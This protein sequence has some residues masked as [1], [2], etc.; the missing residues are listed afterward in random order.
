[1][2]PAERA[3]P[4]SPLN[5]PDHVD[6]APATVHHELL[7][8]GAYVASVSTVYR[9]LREHGEARERR[10]QAIRPEPVA[11]SAN[12]VRPW[13]ITRL[14]G[15][16]KWPHL[17]TY[18]IIFVYS[19]NV[20]GRLLADRGSRVPAEKLLVGAITERHIDRHTPTA[21]A[22]NGTSTASEPVAFPLTGPGVAKSRSR[23]R[24]PHGHPQGG[25]RCGTLKHRPG[26]PDRFNTAEQARPSPRAFLT[27]YDTA[28]RYSGTA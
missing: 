28:H 8:E 10:R 22:G 19:C 26:L 16:A 18:A 12:R 13:D 6:K 24:V 2:T 17:H 7:D 9:I 21:H 4:W 20:M 15:P 23:P 14:A 3:T 11:T 1:M 5:R 27:W 25:A